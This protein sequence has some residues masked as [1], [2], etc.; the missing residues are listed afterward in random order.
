MCECVCV[1]RGACVCVC[2]GLSSPRTIGGKMMTAEGMSGDRDAVDHILAWC[3]LGELDTIGGGG[4][5]PRLPG[6]V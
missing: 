4:V 2:S 5:P 3:T 1:Y 6:D